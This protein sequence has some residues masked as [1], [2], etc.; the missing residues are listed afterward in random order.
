MST[1]A[2]GLNCLVIL[3]GANARSAVALFRFRSKNFD[4]RLVQGSAS[5]PLGKSNFC[6]SAPNR[7]KLGTQVAAG[8]RSVCAKFQ[9][10][11]L[12][13]VKVMRGSRW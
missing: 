1:I 10:I 4:L 8:L 5:A 11:W 2:D 9:P 6:F 3:V 13:D 7:M 12:E